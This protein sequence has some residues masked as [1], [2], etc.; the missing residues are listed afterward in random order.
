M[1]VSGKYNLYITPY[2]RNVPIVRS[3]SLKLDKDDSLAR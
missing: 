2:T 3:T 1:Y